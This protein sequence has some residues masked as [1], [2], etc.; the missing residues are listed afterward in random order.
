MRQSLPGTVAGK[1]ALVI[2]DDVWRTVDL[3]PFLAESPRS[4]L[5]FTTRNVYRRSDWSPWNISRI[6]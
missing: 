2:V 3:E 1:A 5:L 6:C 4:R